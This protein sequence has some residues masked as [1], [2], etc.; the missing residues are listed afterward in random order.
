[1]ATEPNHRHLRSLLDEIRRNDLL[2]NN[3]SEDRCWIEVDGCISQVPVRVQV[4]LPQDRWAAPSQL[5]ASP[6]IALRYESRMAAWNLDYMIEAFDAIY[7]RYPGI[8]GPWIT[9]VR[10]GDRRTYDGHDAW[11]MSRVGSMFRTQP[12]L[13]PIRGH[14]SEEQKKEAAEVREDVVRVEIHT[15]MK[16]GPGLRR[17]DTALEFHRD[18]DG[19]VERVRFGTG[20]VETW[21]SEFLER[22]TQNI[23]WGGC[24][25]PDRVSEL[26]DQVI[27]LVELFSCGVG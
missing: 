20:A 5:L 10:T 26:R 12:G 14:P 23:L 17:T 4:R 16:L 1:M 2:E 27:D 19:F 3:L 24:P 21:P 7:G 9:V 13:K 6:P 8:S 18:E 15:E 11:E 25:S 22:V